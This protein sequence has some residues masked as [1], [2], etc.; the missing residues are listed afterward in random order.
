MFGS[1]LV[2]EG[3]GLGRVVGTQAERVHVEHLHG[4]GDGVAVV[5]AGLEVHAGVL[6]QHFDA[7]EL[8]LRRDDVDGLQSLGDLLADRPT[9]IG[10]VDAVG[11]LDREHADALE[12]VG[13][14]FQRAL[15]GLRE[16]DRVVAAAGRLDGP[17]DLRGH[18]VGD[19]EPGGV[20][21][22]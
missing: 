17:V 14:L 18:S 12:V 6:R 22:R 8:G 1:L 9:V 16:G 21:L 3:D 15:G 13:D 19:G 11:S 7:V 4:D 5:G 20:V 2:G 10:G